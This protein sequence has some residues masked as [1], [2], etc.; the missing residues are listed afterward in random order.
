VRLWLLARRL[1]WSLGRQLGVVSAADL[2]AAAGGG[3][4][5]ADLWFVQ[6]RVAGCI[7]Q[8]AEVGRACFQ[9][10]AGR[11]EQAVVPAAFRQPGHP[12]GQAAGVRR[13]LGGA[14]AAALRLG[15]EQPGDRGPVQPG[16]ALVV[17]EQP[18]GPAGDLGGR[19]EDVAAAGAEVQV[20]G[21]QSPVALLGSGEVGVQ[22]A[23]R[24]T[25]IRAGAVRQALAAEPAECGETSAIWM[26]V[27]VEDVGPGQP[28]G[29]RDVLLRVARPPPADLV[30]VGGG[31]EEPVPGGRD[32][33]PRA[34]GEHR[35]ARP[36]VPQRRGEPEIGRLWPGGHDGPPLAGS[37]VPLTAGAGC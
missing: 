33:L 22:A 29:D 6:P 3:E 24:G 11:P 28:G 8:L 2:G 20:M 23:A 7:G 17:L 14:L 5:T 35:P 32:L 1:R 9:G 27:D 16:L 26:D 13:P 34:A 36:G 10:A 30:Q 21:G 18:V 12:A 31:V 25:D 4:G 19:G 15:I 37:G